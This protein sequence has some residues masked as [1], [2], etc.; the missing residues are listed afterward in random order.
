MLLLWAW[1][2]CVHHRT[3]GGWR[4]ESGHEHPRPTGS[5][6]QV[7]RCALRG[8]MHPR[9]SSAFGSVNGGTMATA[10]LRA[11][12]FRRESG[13]WRESRGTNIPDPPEVL[14]RSVLVRREARWRLLRCEDATIISGVTLRPWRPL[15]LCVNLR[16]RNRHPFVA[17]PG[18]GKHTM[19][20]PRCI[21]ALPLA[22][23]CVKRRYDATAALIGLGMDLHGFSKGESGH[24]HSRPTGPFPQVSP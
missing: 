1:V 2:G 11:V 12:W 10:A 9:T 18:N 4:G 19:Q 13:I 3:F 7:R 15:R 23:G 6:F 20:Q 14:F 24:E 17:L 22:L 21:L 5:P 16:H 8:T